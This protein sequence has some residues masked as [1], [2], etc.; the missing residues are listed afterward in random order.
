MPSYPPIRL[1]MSPVVG[2]RYRS[3]NPPRRGSGAS[4]T[5]SAPCPSPTPRWSPRATEHRQATRVCVE[6]CCRLKAK[7]DGFSDGLRRTCAL[8]TL[9]PT[10]CLSTPQQSVAPPLEDL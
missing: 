10:H 2:T 3:A 9:G 1:P 8:H 5:T 4:S 6:H 7:P